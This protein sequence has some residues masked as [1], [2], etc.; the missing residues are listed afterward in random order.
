[1]KARP[2]RAPSTALLSPEARKGATTIELTEAEAQSVES[3]R[4]A[5]P[6]PTTLPARTLVIMPAT[7]RTPRS[8]ARSVLAVLG[9]SKTIA[10]A[11]RCTALVAAGYVDVGAA[12]DG[13]D[14][15]SNLAWGYAPGE[16]NT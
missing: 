3:I 14:D 15:K 9:R 5:L 11:P 16:T 6:D 12:S 10:C 2:A 8:L 4:A 13:K 1:M 7:L